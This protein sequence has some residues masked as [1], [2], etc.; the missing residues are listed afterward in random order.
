MASRFC[1]KILPSFTFLPTGDSQAR[2]CELSL[3]DRPSRLRYA[4]SAAFPRPDYIR[5]RYNV[6]GPFRLLFFYFYRLFSRA[7]QQTKRAAGRIARRE[8]GSSR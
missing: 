1:V 5:G 4:W 7:V 6:R 3:P 8:R 2:A